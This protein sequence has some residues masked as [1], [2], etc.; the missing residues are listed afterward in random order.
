M[1]IDLIRNSCREDN[2]ALLLVTHSMDIASQFDR[3]D[4]LEDLN[5]VLAAT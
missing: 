2:V 1:V 3:V 4:R 5:R